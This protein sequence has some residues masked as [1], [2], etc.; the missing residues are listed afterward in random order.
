[1]PFVPGSADKRAVI[2]I[3]ALLVVATVA[4]V[5]WFT[6]WRPTPAGDEPAAPPTLSE[7]EATT[8]ETALAD[9]EPEQVATV[10]S[11]E[12][13]AAYLEEP[14]PV[15]PIGAT[16]TIDRSTFTT[17]DERNALV[18]ARVDDGG[19]VSDVVLLLTLEDDEWRV[20]TS[21]TA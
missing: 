21:V 2:G 15:V 14:A 9:A 16:V 3:A 12:S 6:V 10:L 11:P 19:A 17:T 1:M 5:L 4:A 8:I 7:A 20:L 18:A 13:A